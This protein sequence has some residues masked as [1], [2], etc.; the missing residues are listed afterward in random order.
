MKKR[1][2]IFNFII[3]IFILLVLSCKT[4]SRQIT[5]LQ[6]NTSSRTI[7]FREKKW[8]NNNGF[9][10][11]VIPDSQ[12]YT[13]MD[14]QKF[15]YIPYVINQW[16]IYYR[17]TAFIA[18]NSVK[19]GGDFSF[20]LH[21]GDHVDHRNWRPREWKLSAICFENLN[22]QLPVITVPGNHDYD[23]WA[24]TKHQTYG[25]NTYNKYYGPES[26]F[27]KDKEWYKGSSQ[28]GRNS[29]GII[30]A[31][32]K[33]F[34]V[35]GLELNPDDYSIIWAQEVLDRYK[36]LPAIILI[37][38]YLSRNQ[39]T[40]TNANNVET[41]VTYGE[42][43]KKGVNFAFTNVNYRIKNNGWTP[44]KLWDKFISNN[45]Q[46]FLVVCGHVGTETKACGYRIDKNKNGFTTYS[47]LSNFQDFR[48]YLNE[49]GIKY[50][51]KPHACGDG[52]F[53][54]I[55]ID[56]QNN[57]IDFSCFNSETG[58]FMRGEP[59]EMSFPIDWDWDERLGIK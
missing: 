52:W 57:Q 27:F 13:N 53:S 8:E 20:A 42:E 33:D 31:A 34:I 9:S 17:Q 10:I 2:F 5:M 23:T 49:H 24:G 12:S 58:K 38:E 11:A 32:D 28:N 54:I 18:Q 6:S 51:R 41:I 26:S 15:N 29:Y 44:S 22:G 39:E 14:S 59:F 50:K 21:V 19:N 4:N 3:T 43:Y 45:N 48:N 37:H 56:L 30:N 16:E 46:I 36:N 47:L 35:I 40:Q 55:D 25:S 1:F 7:P